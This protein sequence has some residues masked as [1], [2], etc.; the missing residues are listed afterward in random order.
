MQAM[1]NAIAKMRQMT[2]HASHIVNPNDTY[3]RP[4]GPNNQPKIYE[5]TSPKYNLNESHY[6]E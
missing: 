3:N 2:M 4:K 5:S 1:E 6:I